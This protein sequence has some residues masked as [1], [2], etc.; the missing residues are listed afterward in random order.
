MFDLFKAVKARHYLKIFRRIVEDVDFEVERR[1]N[2]R[3]QQ[4][5]AATNATHLQC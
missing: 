3:R 2:A 4:R 5:K 1:K